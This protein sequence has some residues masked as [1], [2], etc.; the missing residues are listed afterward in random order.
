MNIL[1]LIIA[2]WDYSYDFA[3]DFTYDNNIFSY[4]EEYIDDFIQQVRPYRFPFETYDDLLSTATL[5]LYLRNKFFHKRTTTFNVNIDIN[6]YLNNQPKDYQQIGFGMRQSFG[7][8]ALKV[9]YQIIPNFL[10]RYYRTPQGQSADYRGCEV[11]YHTISGK[12]S[13]VATPSHKFTIGYK[14]R[15]EDY[16]SEFSIY[17][18]KGHIVDIESESS[19]RKKIVVSGGYAFRTSQNDA[20]AI[21]STGNDDIPD[22]SYNQH[23]LQVSLIY[24]FKFLLPTK[25]GVG[26]KYLLRNFSTSFS[27]DLLHFGRQDH[28]H[29]ITVSTEF[30]IFTGML[31]TVAYTRQWRNATSD[32]LPSIDRIKDYSKDCVQAGLNFYH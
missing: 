17:D 26:Y 5:R 8:F 22:G 16:I 1:I 10:I 31:F 15:W 25:V 29:K 12:L 11:S 28:I 7:K 30:R 6:H 27:A 20:G 9:S 19:F 21:L 2:V 18:A 4:S 23:S 13:F 32:I 3:A 14:Q 24:P